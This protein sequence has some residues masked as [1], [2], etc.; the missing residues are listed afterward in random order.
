VNTVPK[1]LL[2]S[3]LAVP[4]CFCAAQEK[5]EPLHAPDGGTV[6]KF[7]SIT[8]PSIPNAPF[9]ATVNTEW[10]RHLPDGSNITLKNHRSIARDG[11]GRIF[12]QRA[13]FVP[14]NGDR[15]SA[16][17]Q[18]EISDPA[19]R[20]R[21]ICRTIERTCRIVNFLGVAIP[22]SLDA[23]APKNAPED[24][25]FTVESLGKQIVAGLETIGTRET[26]LVAAASI[27]NEAP[28]LERKE[29]WYS[30]QLGINLIT[31][32][33]DPRFSTQ[34]NFEV[35]DVVLGE[36]DPSLF[37]PPAGFKILDLRNPPEAA[38]PSASS[39]PN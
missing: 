26:R 10:I 30:P 9:T 12:E 21:Y 37:N 29:F 15:K 1:L 25:G 35:S 16:P 27:G 4:L 32:R 33:E 5:L 23:A 7:A 20:S 34:Q 24:S 17:Y 8:I 22:R 39:S 28:I 2:S 19:V 11:Q 38:S 18:T 6:E 31:R 13:W 3:F 14:D 36:P